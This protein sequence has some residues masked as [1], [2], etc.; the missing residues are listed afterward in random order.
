[1]PTKPK[2]VKRKRPAER[3]ADGV[4]ARGESVGPG[5][6]D[7]P[8]GATHEEVRAAGTAARPALKRRRFALR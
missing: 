7:L 8:P 6:R 2:T 5:T 1:M 3:F 4:R